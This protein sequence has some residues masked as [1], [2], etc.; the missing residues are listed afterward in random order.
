MQNKAY[1]HSF[2]LHYFAPEIEA[3][4]SSLRLIHPI[5]RNDGRLEDFLELQGFYKVTSGLKPSKWSRTI[6]D[7]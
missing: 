4:D 3:L 5:K 7:I 2:A 1:S 6:K